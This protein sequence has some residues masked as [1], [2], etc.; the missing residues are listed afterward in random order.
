MTG[1]D[2]LASTIWSKIQM[3]E[4]EK[5]SEVFRQSFYALTT[6]L[7]FSNSEEGASS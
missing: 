5:W 3:S 1:S 2:L 7:L 4:L 6:I